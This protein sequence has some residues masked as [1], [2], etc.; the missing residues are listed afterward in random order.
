MGQFP[1][2]P[3]GEGLQCLRDPLSNDAHSIV[4]IPEKTP[5]ALARSLH[6]R[7]ILVRSE[8]EEAE[9]A[10]LLANGGYCEGFIVSGHPGIGSPPFPSL[11]VEPN[12]L[13]SGKT[14]FLIWLFI[15]HIVLGLP[16]AIQ[17][18]PDD[19]FLFNE[20]GTSRFSN[21]HNLDSYM[22]FHFPSNLFARLWVLVDSN[23]DLLWLWPIF[24]YSV[25]F[26]VVEALSPGIQ[27]LEWTDKMNTEVFYMR[28]WTSDEVRQVSV[29]PTL[30]TVDSAD[31]FCGRPI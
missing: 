9:L 18:D 24:T 13:P 20:G 11:S 23:L 3:L 27:C 10:I 26:F 14:I 12:F 5:M 25:A 6:S 31:A 19:V 15:G 1:R 8:Y 22:G 30:L 16:T 2:Y 17:V 7:K 21:L 4:Q 29:T 28:T